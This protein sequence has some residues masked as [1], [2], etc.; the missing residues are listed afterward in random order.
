MVEQLP[1]AAQLLKYYSSHQDNVKIEVVKQ[2]VKMELTKEE[3]RELMK[4]E[5]QGVEG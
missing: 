1:P 4:Q 3:V 2:Q 5:V